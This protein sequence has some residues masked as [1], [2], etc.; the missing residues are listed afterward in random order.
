MPDNRM[1][2]FTHRATR[3]IERL[4]RALLPKLHRV[5]LL[6]A[7]DHRHPSLG[8]ERVEGS[9]RKRYEVRLDD[10]YRLIVEAQ[11]QAFIVLTVAAHDQAYRRAPLIAAPETLDL[12]DSGLALAESV[13]EP[14][15]AGLFDR[16]L[17]DALLRAGVPPDRLE[18]VILCPDEDALIDLGLDE[19]VAERLLDALDAEGGR[20]LLSVQPESEQDVARALERP[21]PFRWK[22]PEEHRALLKRKLDGPLLVKGSAGSGKTS[23]A[24]HRALLETRQTELFETAGQAPVLFLCFNRLLCRAMQWAFDEHLGAGQTRV[25]VRTI[26]EWCQA[27]LKSRGR[28]ATI[29]R[30]DDAQGLIRDALRKVRFRGAQGDPQLLERSV[31]FFQEE[32]QQVIEGRPAAHWDAYRKINRFGR[33]FPLEEAQRQTVWQ[34]YEEVRRLQA[35]YRGLDWDGL[36]L[37]AREELGR[38]ERPP[39]Y[40]LV[41]VDEAQ[42]FSPVKLAIAAQL[43]DQGKVLFLADAAQNIYRP[44]FQWKDIG[45]NL[46]GRTEILTRNLRQS[47]ALHRFVRALGDRIVDPRDTAGPEDALGEVPHHPSLKAGHPPTIVRC[48]HL[49][50]E[51]DFVL[52]EVTRRV[53]NGEVEPGRVCILALKNRV[54]LALAR[55]LRERGLHVLTHQDLGVGGDCVPGARDAV[56]VMTC[57]SAKGLDFPIVYLV[58]VN[59]NVFPH[60]TDEQ[61]EKDAAVHLER[62]RRVLFVAC[63]RAGEELWI[64]HTHNEASPFLEEVDPALV[65]RRVFPLAP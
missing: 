22:L 35:A 59:R 56:K 40:R 26:D 37:I 53:K 48:P 34:V 7:R 44:G 51:F 9:R 24:F 10:H 47:A 31:T 30:P 13:A 18:A 62:S 12:S 61:D 57:H 16:D 6:L 42:D 19:A 1:I 8:T 20:P 52:S 32:I 63:S 65:R 41:V 38:D 11:R 21:V 23:L 25:E 3:E 28:A 64:T 15:P 54:V 29:L 17:A 50:D 58:D 2:A 43:A 5:L 33:R 49:E 36:G 55:R 14:A 60:E 46:S 45:L 4:D 27:Y 39:L